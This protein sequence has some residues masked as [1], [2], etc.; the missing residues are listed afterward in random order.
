MRVVGLPGEDARPES[1]GTRNSDEHRVTLCTESLRE[2]S[3]GEPALALLDEL[4]ASPC[5]GRRLDG[6]R[7]LTVA[8]ASSPF[9][10]MEGVRN[11]TLVHTPAIGNDGRVTDACG[12]ESRFIADRTAE[13]GSV[14]ARTAASL[15]PTEEDETV[16][17]LL[18]RPFKAASATDD[19]NRNERHR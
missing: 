12:E 8:F 13:A 2:P 10:T 16:R 3:G 9:K 19:R 6:A 18:R 1:E 15:A 4:P 11:A 7:G 14:S 17:I 5:K